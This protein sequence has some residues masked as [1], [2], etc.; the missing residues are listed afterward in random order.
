VFLAQSVQDI[1]AV[2]SGIIGELLGDYFKG[3]SKGRHN[4]Q[5]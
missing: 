4:E 2:N 3:T 5:E 1:G